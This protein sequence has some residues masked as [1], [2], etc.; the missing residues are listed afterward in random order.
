MP[1]EFTE[2]LRKKVFG[3]RVVGPKKWVPLF[4]T[5]LLAGIDNENDQVPK[6]RSVDA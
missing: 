6:G 2:D 5:T 4:L 1:D 3:G